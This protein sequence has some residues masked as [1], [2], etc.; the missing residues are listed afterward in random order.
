[1]SLITILRG[2]TAAMLLLCTCCS[3]PEQHDQGTVDGRERGFLMSG[4]AGRALLDQCSRPAPAPV[5][6]FWIPTPREI[7][8]L[9]S[10]IDTFLTSRLAEVSDQPSDSVARRY[11]RQYVG[12]VQD[13][14]H[15]IYING[16]H[17]TEA[18][19]LAAGAEAKRLG[20]SYF[21]RMPVVAC[22]GGR[23][24]WGVVYDV[25]SGTFEDFSFNASVEG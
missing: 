15:L 3:S 5:E 4:S 14:R 17:E 13:N 7:E 10:R 18:E 16:F 2:H 21:S 23:A 9:E 1:M 12:F 25:E 22:D 11:F 6:R 20:N 19:D 24:F 8:A